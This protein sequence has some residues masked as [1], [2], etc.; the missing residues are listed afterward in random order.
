MVVADRCRRGRGRKAQ[1]SDQRRNQNS[2]KRPQGCSALLRRLSL[3]HTELQTR[4]TPIGGSDQIV[5]QHASRKSKSSLNYRYLGKV[6]RSNLQLFEGGHFP[7]NSKPNVNDALQQK[8][9]DIA[10]AAT[11]ISHVALQQGRWSP[12]WCPIQPTQ[13]RGHEHG[14]DESK[15]GRREDQRHGNHRDGDEERLRKPSRTAS[16]RP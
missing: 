6:K 5:P 12:S 8:S 2:R 14:N 7:L 16:T 9:L 1:H 3:R 10:N 11:H 4:S 13:G 15:G